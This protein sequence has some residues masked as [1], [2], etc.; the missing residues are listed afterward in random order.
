MAFRGRVKY[1]N[2]SAQVREVYSPDNPPPAPTIPVTSVN[3]KTGAVVLTAADVGAPTQSAFDNVVS[4]ATVVGAAKEANSLSTGYASPQSSASIGWYKILSIS[5]SRIGATSS[6]RYSALVEFNG[7]G[8][9]A[10]TVNTA[11]SGTVEIDVQVRNETEFFP[12]RLVI[13]ILNGYLEDNF[14]CGAFNDD[15]SELSIYVR[16]HARVMQYSV[17][18]L[19]ENCDKQKVHAIEFVNEFYGS[20]PPASAV[21][22]TLRNRSSVANRLS[23]TSNIG[24]N[25]L[26]VYFSAGGVPVKCDSTLVVDITGNAGSASKVNNALT[27]NVNGENIVFDGSAAKSV[28]IEAELEFVPFPNGE[29]LN[30][31]SWE[32]LNAI[33]VA[34]A[35]PL[36]F[37]NLGDEKTFTAGSNTYSAKLVDTKYN[38]VSGLVFL[39]TTSADVVYKVWDTEPP[40]NTGGWG[41]SPLRSSLNGSFLSSIQADLQSVIKEVP[42]KYG[43]GGSSYTSQSEVSSVNCKLF[44][45][46][47]SEIQ[48]NSR[49]NVSG[50][51]SPGDGSDGRWDLGTKEGEQLQYFKNNPANA[52]I[53]YAYNTRTCI[54]GQQYIAFIDTHLH[55]ESSNGLTCYAVR[56]WGTTTAQRLAFLFVV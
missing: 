11:G 51:T 29:S 10:D 47:V 43:K 35:D 39:A 26:P 24:S 56:I 3:N 42:V 48:G 14:I 53:G 34:G 17:G 5:T 30:D 18:V 4:G 55:T 13:N 2:D 6:S 50:F 36:S 49:V 19:M 12:A 38:G 52:L 44:L 46:A 8:E 45:P 41:V 28:S 32:Q 31:C 40:N 37:F 9:P 54:S 21:F 22:P 25:K 33:S 16:L 27:L 7:V 1:Y 23:N 20:S 15:V